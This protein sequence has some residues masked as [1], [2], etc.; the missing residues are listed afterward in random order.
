VN[1][2]KILIA[3]VT[4]MALLVVAGVA[5]ANGGSGDEGD[6]SYKG[7]IAAPEQGGPSLQ[8]LAKIDRATAERD[9][10]KPVPGTVEETDLE[11]ENGSV[12]YGVEIAGNDG[13]TYDVKVD[14]G[15]GE[16]L[17]QQIVV[18]DGSGDNEDAD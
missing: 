16:I 10:L 8:E 1:A 11:V 12:V 2:K 18:V 13:K 5:Y 9:A 17:S 15:N 7:S 14:A 4:A 6:G 3:A